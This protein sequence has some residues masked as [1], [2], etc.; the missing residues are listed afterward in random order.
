MKHFDVVVIGGGP[1]GMNAGMMLNKM[2]KS[3]ALIQ[4][5]QDSFGGVCLNRGCMPTKSLLK[6]AKVYREAK[7]G[8]KYGL[9]LSAAP[10]DLKRLRAV[11]DADLDNLRNMAQGMMAENPPAFFRG[12]G[13]F[14]SDHEVEVTKKDGTAE[15]VHGDIII[16]ATGSEAVPLP[17]A[18]FDGQYVLSSDQI[19]Q[20]TQLPEKLLIIGGG[21]IGCEFASMYQSFGSQIILV[22]AQDTLLPNEDPEVGKTLQQ[23]F[24]TQGIQVKTGFAIEALTPEN[25]RVKV[26]Y[27]G[28]DALDYV[29][30]VLVG[31]GRKP[32][33][34]G[35]NLAA[36]G[37][38]T[39][40]RAVKVNELMQ[41][42]VAHIYALGD[43]IGKLMLAHAANKQAMQLVMNL[44]QGETRPL[45]LSGV[46]RVVFCFPEVATVGVNR[47]TEAVKSV[48][49]PR[50]PNGRT[51]VDKTAPAFVKL[52]IEKESDV[53]AGAAIIGEAATEIIHELAVA[54]ENRLTVQQIRQTVHAHPT[55][56]TCVAKALLF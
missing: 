48:C 51:V 24:V 47:E 3:V 39:E 50:A 4:E 56:S 2:G 22:E 36:A 20:N 40:K 26:K 11:V 1:G 23:A 37:V 8:K 30:K 55:H 13:A 34:T 17:F 35:L 52:F 15:T 14:R 41:T 9:E 27:Q 54:V 7:Q 18:P 25:G 43:V 45:I 16:I 12:T 6:A 5:E 38:E 42:G 46:P 32:N 53:I 33:I 29:D 10:I 28:C 31:V 21:A 19:L 44:M 49:L